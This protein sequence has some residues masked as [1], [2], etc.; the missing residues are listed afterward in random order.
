[1][2][3]PDG[4]WN[5]IM[6]LPIRLHGD[7]GVTMDAYGPDLG[8]EFLS[9]SPSSSMIWRRSLCAR[10]VGRA[11]EDDGCPVIKLPLGREG[12]AAALSFA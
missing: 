11:G 8:R 6:S 7:V 3:V 4:V 12:G 1:M 9:G 10:L 2:T 5:S